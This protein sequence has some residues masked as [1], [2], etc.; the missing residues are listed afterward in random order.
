MLHFLGTLP[1]YFL[2]KTILKAKNTRCKVILVSLIV[3]IRNFFLD[4]NINPINSI[5][6]KF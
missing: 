2:A 3:V 4:L 6:Q 1:F 5:L